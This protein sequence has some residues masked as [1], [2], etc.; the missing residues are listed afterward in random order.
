VVPLLKD[1]PVGVETPAG[2]VGHDGAR[3]N[4]GAAQCPNP[5][6]RFPA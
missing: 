6:H 3:L 4:G 5:R 2:H 1:E